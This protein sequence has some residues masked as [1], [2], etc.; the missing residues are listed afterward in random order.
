MM[1]P[2]VCHIRR[3]KSIWNLWKGSYWNDTKEKF[4]FQAFFLKDIYGKRA[5]LFCW[6]GVSEI[7][8][9]SV[10]VSFIQSLSFF[11]SYKSNRIED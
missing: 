2:K 5:E 1:M 11:G 7:L 4:C 9:L 10:K 8:K 6:S 3:K